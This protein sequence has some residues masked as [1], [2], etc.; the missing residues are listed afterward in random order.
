MYI[1][2][3]HVSLQAT[4]NVGSAR[5]QTPPTSSSTPPLFPTV[6]TAVTTPTQG[7]LLAIHHQQ[8]RYPSNHH[9]PSPVPPP[10]H[11]T[12]LAVAPPT[13]TASALQPQAQGNIT[14]H[15]QS[16]MSYLGHQSYSL[17]DPLQALK[18]IQPIVNTAQGQGGGT[19][20][21]ASQLPT[22]TSTA[23]PY[24]TLNVSVGNT[25]ALPRAPMIHQSYSQMPAQQMAYPQ[26]AAA[27][28]AQA[29]QKNLSASA[30]AASLPSALRVGTLTTAINYQQL[31]LLN[32][33]G[34]GSTGIQAGVMLQTGTG[35]GTQ[36]IGSMRTGQQ[37]LAQ[38][39]T[40]GQNILT[41]PPAK[42]PAYDL[43]GYH[44]AAAGIFQANLLPQNIAAAATTSL[45]QT[46]LSTQQQ[47]AKP[48]TLLPPT[49]NNL[50]MNRVPPLMSQQ[51]NT[52]YRASNQT[53]PGVPTLVAA[54]QLPGGH[55]AAA[56]SMMTQIGGRGRGGGGITGPGHG[57][58][59]P[60][61]MHLGVAGSPVRP[62]LPQQQQ[63]Q[64][65]LLYTSPSPRD[66]T[67]SRM[68]SSA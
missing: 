25:T 40:L 43:T 60:Q 58:S 63:Q 26:T 42:R 47:Y 5:Q 61:Q 34:V 44:T 38:A 23:L 35:T 39:Q 54:S 22:P 59:L 68:P 3:F 10:T 62:A 49:S 56:L 24:S 18:A 19:S 46:T 32:V 21:L 41:P 37:G 33:A 2:I 17:A 65:C 12:P 14:T 16:Q 55:Q 6:S 1:L 7:Q 28:G 8:H 66:A 29:V 20:A 52:L 27:H 53:L 9:S 67:L 15:Q 50:T 11:G 48:P 4:D 13:C 36:M 45:N 31:N 51:P 57:G 30:N 64:H